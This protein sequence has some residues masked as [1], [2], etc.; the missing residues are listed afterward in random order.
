MSFLGFGDLVEH[1]S[2][3]DPQCQHGFIGIYESPGDPG[4]MQIL[5]QWIQDTS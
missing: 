3:G 2:S 1:E 5:A 4:K